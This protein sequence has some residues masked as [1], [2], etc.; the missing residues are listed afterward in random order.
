MAIRAL[1]R[2]YIIE[3]LISV[4]CVSG[5][6]SNSE[7]VRK[8]FPKASSMPTTD[9]RGGMKT[10]IDDIRRHMDFNDDWEY[11]FLF[12][13]YLNLLEADEQDFVYFLEQYVHPSIRRFDWDKENCE[14]ISFENSRCVA[15]INKYLTGEGYELR[16][17]DQ[18]GN[19][20]I[21]SVVSL[22]VGVQGKIKNIIFA[23]KYK[24]EIVFDDALNN[25]VRI[26]NNEDQC[27]IYYRPI[28]SDG[29]K[30]N[31]LVEW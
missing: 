22:N 30:W 7:F 13:E 2:Q 12:F 18:I 17:T 29:L 11:E 25:D 23:A 21:Y 3:D 15:V 28:P 16:P 19:L 27:L 6:M 4:G 14:Q 24:P 31:A 1:A 5:Q 20:P 26:T 9:K 10:A 8:V